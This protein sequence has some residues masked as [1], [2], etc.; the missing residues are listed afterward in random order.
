MVSIIV[1]NAVEVSCIAGR[2]LSL[3]RGGSNVCC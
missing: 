1:N 2:V 3:P